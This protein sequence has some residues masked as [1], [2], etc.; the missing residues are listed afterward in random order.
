MIKGNRSEWDRLMETLERYSGDLDINT[1]RRWTELKPECEYVW[2][3]D[4][5]T[6]R[7]IKLGRDY[8]WY[9]EHIEYKVSTTDSDLVKAVSALIDKV[10]NKERYL[11]LYDKE[12]P[13]YDESR[14]DSTI[15]AHEKRIREQQIAIRIG[16][17]EPRV[18]SFPFPWIAEEP[19]LDVCSLYNNDSVFEHYEQDVGDRGTVYFTYRSQGEWSPVKLGVNL[20]ETIL[21]AEKIDDG[22]E[23]KLELP[24]NTS[25]EDLSCGQT[26]VLFKEELGVEDTAYMHL[27]PEVMGLEFSEAVSSIVELNDHVEKMKAG[28]ISYEPHVTA[29]LLHSEQIIDPGD[30]HIILREDLNRKDLKFPSLMPGRMRLAAST[31]SL[32]SIEKRAVKKGDGFSV[33]ICK[34]GE[35]SFKVVVKPEQ[36]K[37]HEL[38]QAEIV[39]IEE[40]DEGKWRIG[41][42]F[43]F[44][45]SVQK[46]ELEETV[47]TLVGTLDPPR[48]RTYELAIIGKRDVD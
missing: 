24:E 13:L 30:F 11:V 6:I 32:A 40:T 5:D 48:T 39:F 17:L 27:W 41:G 8:G 37:S 44:K 33:Y 1:I 35:S 2:D 28:T 4:G 16:I 21:M 7:A 36:E 38:A 19:H 42:A 25:I 34:T 43:Q 20:E 47:W 9:V 18:V 14:T 45:C 23:W 22:E 3:C 15:Q 29:G 26:F 12:H 46:E 31:E 10:I